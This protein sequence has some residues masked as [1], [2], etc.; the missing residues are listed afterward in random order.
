VNHA[1]TT[2]GGEPTQYRCFD[3]LGREVRT[4]NQGFAGTLIDVDTRYDA[5]GRIARVSEPYFAGG[6]TYWN[7]TAYDA[8]GRISAVQAADGND[9]TY[10][11]DSAASLCSTPA[12]ARQTLTTN[13]LGHSQLEVRNALGETIQVIDNACGS[14]SSD[15]DATGNPAD[16]G[17]RCPDHHDLRSGRAQDVDERPGQ[18][19]L[20]IRLECPRRADPP[21]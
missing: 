19:H 3:R 16:R 5:S 11:Y 17:R 14:V 15:Y 6:T 9:L 10:D 7:D 18:G 13:G 2:G 8:I 4:A 21:A 20:A 1:I 12:A